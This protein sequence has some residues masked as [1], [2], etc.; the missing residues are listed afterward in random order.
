MKESPLVW[1][2]AGN[3]PSC[4]AGIQFDARVIR[5]LGGRPCA[6]ASALTAQST[7]RVHGVSPVDP[8]FLTRQMEALLDDGRPAAVKTGMLGGA[9]QVAAVARVLNTMDAYVVCD[10]VILSS[11]GFPLLDAEGVACLKNELFPRIDLLTPNLPECAQLTGKSTVT[12]EEL[13]GLA[14]QLL[15]MGPKAVLIKGGHSGGSVCCDYFSDGKRAF[16]VCSPRRSGPGMHGT[17]CCFSAATATAVALGY[18]PVDAVVL[19]KTYVNQA[20]RTAVQYGTG[21]PCA[22]VYAWP[23]C[24]ED[25]PWISEGGSLP[26]AGA[27][28]PDCG[29]EPLGLYPLVETAEWAGK[30]M[31][32]GV[33]AIQL[34]VKNQRPD[35]VEAEIR[36]AVALS[37]ETGCRLFVNDYWRAAIRYGAYG[38]HLGQNDLA[39]A[40]IPAIRSAGLRLG[41][42][43]H[44]FFELAHALAW[45]PSYVAM[46]TVFPSPSKPELTSHLG[47]DNLKKMLRLAGIPVVAIGGL[48]V[49]NAGPVVQAGVSGV[50]VI[51][52]IRDASDVQERVNAWRSL[53]QEHGGNRRNQ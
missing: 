14:G 53:F 1:S 4:G 32:L 36:Q 33:S 45:R 46:G 47:V 35:D 43:T 26:G 42:S 38:V 37:R 8:A 15:A 23:E 30:L 44:S 13:P 28:F 34:R 22:A 10:P 20:I 18:D 27:A 50:A 3:D 17:G 49:E 5:A 2:I 25:F 9:G 48:H 6:V 21:A 16:W 39:G 51:S 11:S 41:T 24:S 19:A 12:E 31:R 7:C 52:D 40:D 29:P